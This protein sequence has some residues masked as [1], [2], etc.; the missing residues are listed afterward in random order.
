MR[1]HRRLFPVNAELHQPYPPVCSIF[2]CPYSIPLRAIRSNVD[3]ESRRMREAFVSMKERTENH[4]PSSNA[5]HGRNEGA[6]EFWSSVAFHAC[7]HLS[8]QLKSR[9]QG[10]REEST[11]RIEIEMN[12]RRFSS[13]FSED[14]LN[15][16]FI[17]TVI[18][19]CT[20]QR[21]HHGFTYRE[22]DRLNENFGDS[23]YP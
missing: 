1:L 6:F 12:R 16:H 9:E 13:L 5:A 15:R 17:V 18:N 21:T 2:V 19:T 7:I 8:R 10:Q 22:S 11:V 4:E 14:H 23:R 3:R 20:E